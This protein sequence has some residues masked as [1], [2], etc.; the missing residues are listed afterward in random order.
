MRPELYRTKP[1]V[2]KIKRPPKNL[3]LD[4][5]TF[6]ANSI[7]QLEE[8][9]QNELRGI[10]SSN[11]LLEQLTIQSRDGLEDLHIPFLVSPHSNETPTSTWSTEEILLAIQSF[12][13][14]GKEFSTIARIIG[15][16]KT[17]A[18][19]EKFYFEH[20]DRYQLDM[21]VENYSSKAARSSVQKKGSD[22]ILFC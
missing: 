14:Y 12:A 3:S 15:A 20:R 10:Q 19:V 4:L 1:A 8:D 6:N 11:Q 13:K 5:E 18:D 16:T 2:K 9:I 17:V 22:E 7:N 21:I